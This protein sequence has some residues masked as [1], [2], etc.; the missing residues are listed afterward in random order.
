MKAGG[1]SHG[2]QRVDQPAA[3]PAISPSTA[4]IGSAQHL[5]EKVAAQAQGQDRADRGSISPAAMTPSGRSKAAS[6]V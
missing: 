1:R 6:S 5:H 2:D 4:V 3:V